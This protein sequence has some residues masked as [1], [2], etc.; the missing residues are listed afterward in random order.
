MLK[1][2]TDLTVLLE[3]WPLHYYEIDDVLLRRKLLE[4][5]S[6]DEENRQLLAIWNQRFHIRNGKAADRFMEAWL[7]LKIASD[8]PVGFLNRKAKEK[9]L[10][11]YAGFLHLG[12]TS[13]KMRREWRDFARTLLITCADTR[14]YRTAIFGLIDLGDKITA[15]RI[16]EEIDRVTG[17]Y[18]AQLQQEELFREFRNVLIQAYQDILNHGAELW[19]EYLDQAK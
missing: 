13:E 18:P 7:M 14:A 16:A 19:Q 1:K 12:D 15:M 5:H 11:K 6:D 8:V 4:E 2:E 3:N 10:L 17:I 9:E